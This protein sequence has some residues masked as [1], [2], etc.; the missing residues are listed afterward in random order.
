MRKR[1]RGSFLNLVLSMIFIILGI[2]K[3]YILFTSSYTRGNSRLNYI[4]IFIYLFLA[5]RYLHMYLL[6]VE[7]TN[8]YLT[9]G[10]FFMDKKV[11]L[12][13]LI[14]IRENGASIETVFRDGTIIKFQKNEID[15]KDIKTLKGLMMN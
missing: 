14:D 12:E 5:W 1:Y 11:N 7:I 10:G 15:R 2:L 13:G 8:K 6:K 9:L 3:S 4:E